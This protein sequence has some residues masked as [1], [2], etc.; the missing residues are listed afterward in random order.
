MNPFTSIKTTKTNTQLSA[1]TLKE[2]RNEEKVFNPKREMQDYL[3]VT[4]D[5]VGVLIP[6]DMKMEFYDA[7]RLFRSR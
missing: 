7:K 1:R 2:F 6:N 5:D 4:I 3:L